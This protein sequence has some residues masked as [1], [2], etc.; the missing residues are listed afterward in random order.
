MKW[1]VATSILL[2]LILA[3]TACGSGPGIEPTA[4]VPTDPGVNLLV[5]AEGEVELRRTR[6]LGQFQF[7]PIG[8]VS[9]V[10]SLGCRAV[11]HR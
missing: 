4:T 5:V 9:G 7:G 10:E 6:T 8:I 3:T 1:R 2:A 11:P